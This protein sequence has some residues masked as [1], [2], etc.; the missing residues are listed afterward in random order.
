MTN[1]TSA[2]MRNESA[3]IHGRIHGPL[4]VSTGRAATEM[5]AITTMEPTRKIWVHCAGSR[6]K[7]R[8]SL[9]TITFERGES[10]FV[11]NRMNVLRKVD[12]AIRATRASCALLL[13]SSYSAVLIHRDTPTSANPPE[14]SRPSSSKGRVCPER[15]ARIT[16]ADQL[17]GLSKGR[18]V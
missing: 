16:F 18:G 10:G 13:P 17:G 2:R 9:L 7:H 6:K 4:K 12:F 1:P 11:Q 15:D 8:I 5:S 14:M 3:L